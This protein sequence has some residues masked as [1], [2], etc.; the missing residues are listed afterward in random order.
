[1]SAAS[2]TRIFGL[3]VGVDP[4]V[5]VGVLIVIALFMFWYNSRTTDESSTPVTAHPVNVPAAVIP[6]RPRPS[7]ARRV[8]N[9]NNQRGT[10]RLRAIDAT[11]GDIDPTLRLDLLARL[12]SV[13]PAS[14]GRS[15]FEVAP[16]PA[17]VLPKPKGPIVIPKP[18]PA[19]NPPATVSSVPVLNIP[20]KYYGFVKPAARGEIN[21]GFFLDGDNVVVA[22]EGELLKQR[23]LVVSLTPNTAR[24]EDTQVKQGQTLQVV[25]AA[26]P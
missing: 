12:Q 14:G 2:Q 22:A 23:Y 5:L 21:R 7:A 16:P 9:T 8:T 20:L 10:L 1:M 11:Q 4:K 17:P 25:P 24:I 3:R 6:P 15:L 18:L 13:Q 26:N 19:P